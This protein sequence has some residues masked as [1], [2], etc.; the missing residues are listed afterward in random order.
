MYYEINVAR[1]GRH[2][3][4]TAKRSL[5]DERAAL[6]LYAEFKTLFDSPEVAISVSYYAEEA[7]DVTAS[8]AKHLFKDGQPE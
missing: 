6:R 8:F 5:T 1:N 3:F 7:R 2:V 4:A